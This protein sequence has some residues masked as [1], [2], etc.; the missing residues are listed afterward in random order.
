VILDGLKN[1][2]VKALKVDRLALP[3]I[4]WHRKDATRSLG[5]TNDGKTFIT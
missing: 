3:S 5:L 4:H 2:T 1:V